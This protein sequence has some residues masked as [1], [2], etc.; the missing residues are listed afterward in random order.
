MRQRSLFWPFF[1]IATGAIWFLVELRTLPVENLW[2]LMYIWPFFLMA[3]GVGLILR[4]RWPFTRMLISGL[5]VLGMVLSIVFAPQL[6]WNKAP[7]WNFFN[8]ADSGGSLRG[9]GVLKT[10]TRNL[11][12]FNSIEVNF[13]V[14][15]TIRQGAATS[16]SIEAE[17]NLLPQLATRVSG[18]R[19][20]IEDNQPDWT[21][22]VNP[23]RPV[24]IQMTVKDL[25]QVDFP[26]A[27]TLAVEDLQTDRLDI[28][29]SGAG[30]VSLDQLT[31][32]NLTVDLS[33]AGN[34]TAS[35]STDNLNLDISGFGGFQGGDLSSQSASI[36]ISGAG[37]ATIWVISSLNVEI[38]GTGSVNYY[39]SPNIQQQQISGLGSVNK[40]GNK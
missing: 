8:F 17:D 6:G 1:L 24:K 27:G 36:T 34:I 18:N 31:A 22:R 26:S 28:S 29:I 12:D 40:A 16:V 21:K 39:G 19:L 35:G 2:A 23:T 14:E 10:E 13:P 37:S 38:S 9:S 15:L 7:S 30:T 4:S 25:Q 32:Q 11:A 5:I 3:A 33:G 20:I